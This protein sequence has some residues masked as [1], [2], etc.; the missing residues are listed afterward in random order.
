MDISIRQLEAFR[1][2]VVS[3]GV[4]AASGVLGISQP[5]IS[6]LISDL[7]YRLGCTL[8][9]RRNKRLLLTPEGRYLYDDVQSS[10]ASLEKIG[11]KA[12]DLQNLKAG[13][14][15]LGTIPSLSYRFLPQVLSEFLEDRPGVSVTYEV[16]NPRETV[17]LVVTQQA[18]LAIVAP[19]Y[20][21]PAIESSPLPSSDCVCVLPPAHSLAKKRVIRPEDLKGESF[22]SITKD[23][24]LRYR[25]DEAFDRCGVQRRQVIETPM[26]STACALSLAGVGI[27]IVDR[28]NAEQSAPSGVLL[29]PFVPRIDYE[30]AIAWPRD[31]A[32]SNLAIQFKEMLQARMADFVHAWPNLRGS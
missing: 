20:E 32:A 25:I 9:E 10:L 8:F 17:E 2:V 23:A 3:G 22:I 12:R 24:L 5:A 15:T 18:D 6:R 1:A 14:L 30:L 26:G 19:P 31:V 29:R 7:E 11:R 13:H 27:T 16:R 21:H 28:F 4:T